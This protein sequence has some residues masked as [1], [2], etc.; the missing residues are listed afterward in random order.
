VL[1]SVDH[2]ARAARDAVRGVLAYYVHRVEPVVLATSGA[3]A[4]E[5]QNICDTVLQ[6]G[7]PAGARLVSDA[8]I[9]TFASAGDPEHVAERLQASMAAGVHA[10]L[11]WHVIGPDPGRS[12]RLLA[13]VVRP[14]VF[15]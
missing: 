3:D 14:R 11:A 7:V 1:L 10:V 9:E 8:L 5:L 15:G 6:E 2:D 13:D 4:G 12:L